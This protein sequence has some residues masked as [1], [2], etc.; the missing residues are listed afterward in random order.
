[1]RHTVIVLFTTNRAILLYVFVDE[2]HAKDELWYKSKM[3][4]WS[5]NGLKAWTIASPQGGRVNELPYTPIQAA[6]EINDLDSG[7][8]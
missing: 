6:R 4:W 5:C 8:T 3:P 7:Y 1:M 2:F